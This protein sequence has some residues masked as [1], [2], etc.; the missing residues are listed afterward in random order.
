M[1][2]GKGYDDVALRKSWGGLANYAELRT[3]LTA[4]AHAIV[5][6][7]QL[8]SAWTGAHV[9]ESFSIFN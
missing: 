6:T 2:A 4:D 1:T 3:F 9:I 8:Q 7:H 5:S